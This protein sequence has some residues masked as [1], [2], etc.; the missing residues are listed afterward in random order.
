MRGFI[1]MA[2]GS[3]LIVAVGCGK[4]EQAPSADTQA[5]VQPATSGAGGTQTP[6]AGRD[7]IVIE[8][9][10]D[11]EGNNRFRPADVEA[12]PGDVLRYT[13]VSGV[14]NVHFLADSNPGA[15]GL[16]AASELLQLPGQTHDIK[17]TW[18]PGRYYFQCD[19]HALLGMIGHVKVE[20][21]DD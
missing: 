9:M 10:T 7:V 3:V 18:K 20:E 6:D 21:E 14:H 16:P 15:Q 4:G 8:M 5:A 1:R 2:L 12:H 11:E 19:P 17:V 13:L